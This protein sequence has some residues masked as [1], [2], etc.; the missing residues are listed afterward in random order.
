[1]VRQAAPSAFVFSAGA[2]R[3]HYVARLVQRGVAMVR[4]L[5]AQ[6]SPLMV[7][8]VTKPCPARL[9]PTTTTS[10]AWSGHGS[11][12]WAELAFAAG[13]GITLEV[14]WCAPSQP[15]WPTWWGNWQPAGFSVAPAFY[16]SARLLPSLQQA[17][18]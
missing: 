12:S 10:K 8:F 2:Y 6:P 15:Q 5:A 18:F 13:H 1:M 11:G 4:Y 7:G 16:H 17:A 3:G 9:V 14:F